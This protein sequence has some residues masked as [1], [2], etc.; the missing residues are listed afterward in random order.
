VF[1]PALPARRAEPYISIIL[2]AVL[3]STSAHIP[4]YVGFISDGFI[5]FQHAL[6]YTL[7]YD[8]LDWEV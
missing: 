5:D 7:A 1:T 2:P 8:G 6:V 3:I 4:D